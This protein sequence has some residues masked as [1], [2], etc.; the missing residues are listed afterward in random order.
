MRKQFERHRNL[1][2]FLGGNDFGR[3]A[4]LRLTRTQPPI[5]KAASPPGAG[6]L[7]GT[8]QFPEDGMSVYNAKRLIPR[9]IEGKV[10][11]APSE[12]EEIETNGPSPTL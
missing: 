5:P 10:T 6:A 7:D 12:V 1:V 8:R 9:S 11:C 3:I 4:L 2:G